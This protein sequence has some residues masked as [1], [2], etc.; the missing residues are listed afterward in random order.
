MIDSFNFPPRNL[1]FISY[2]Y[3]T[4]ASNRLTLL[5]YDI[6]CCVI[7]ETKWFFIIADAFFPFIWAI[8]SNTWRFKERGSFELSVILNSDTYHI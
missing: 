6:I 3:H 8:I 2:Y 4:S 7:I 1:L 5:F